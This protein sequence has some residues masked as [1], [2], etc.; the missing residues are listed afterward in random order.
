MILAYTALVLVKA[1]H[2]G[3]S[4]GWSLGVTRLTEAKFSSR[5][6]ELHTQALK[7]TEQQM[8]R[9]YKG[10]TIPTGVQALRRDTHER[11]PCISLQ[12]LVY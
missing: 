7:A 9:W 10:E 2:L 3:R 5:N 1:K 6:G 8:V 11:H 12:P 4:L